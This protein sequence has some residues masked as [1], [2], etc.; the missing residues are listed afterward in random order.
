[1]KMKG[2]PAQHLCLTFAYWRQDTDTELLLTNHFSL[3]YYHSFLEL[4]L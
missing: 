3:G 4:I 2:L 1:M